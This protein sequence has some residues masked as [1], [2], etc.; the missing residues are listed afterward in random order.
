MATLP[1]LAKAHSLPSST[2]DD[3]E[4]ALPTEQDDK[5]AKVTR[6]GDAVA[7]EHLRRNLSARQVSM[8]AIVRSALS[9]DSR[10]LAD[11][12]RFLTSRRAARSE[13]YAFAAN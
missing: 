2:E 6:G 4:K 11:I 5:P 1:D 3:L 7:P 12:P 13:L 8:I 9:L 10:H